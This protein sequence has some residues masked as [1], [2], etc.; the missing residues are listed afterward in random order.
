MTYAITTLLFFCFR[1]LFALHVCQ[2]ERLHSERN[3]WLINYY[4][5]VTEEIG[6]I[7]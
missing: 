5:L 7:P 6:P 3:D 1:V 4:L 2:L